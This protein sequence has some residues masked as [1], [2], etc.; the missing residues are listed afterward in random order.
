M[1]KIKSEGNS[2]LSLYDQNGVLH[3][4]TQK[5]LDITKQYYDKLFQ[6]GPTNRN[7]ENE[8]LSKSNVRLTQE[9]NSTN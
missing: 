8:I 6:A 3:S 2:I 9:Q 7:L 4:S 1:E 5:I